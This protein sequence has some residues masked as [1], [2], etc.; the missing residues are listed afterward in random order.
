MQRLQ[1]QAAVMSDDRILIRDLLI[2]GILGVLPEERTQKQDILINVVIHHDLRGAATSGDLSRSVDYA[3]VAR[4]IVQR[5]EEGEDF[6]A[7]TL[8]H[9]LARLIVTEFGAAR[10]MVRVEKTSA[11]PSARAVG[12][13]IERTIED[14]VRG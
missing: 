13:E 2:R 9:D 8:A 1:R 3:A 10:V 6:L 14:F 11:I 7:E 12:V 5:V 4:R